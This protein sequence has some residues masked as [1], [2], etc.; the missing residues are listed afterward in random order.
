MKTLIHFREGLSGHYLKALLT[1][2]NT[3]IRFR[4][5]SAGHDFSNYRTWIPE[6]ERLIHEQFVCTHSV[7]DINVQDFDLVLKILVNKKIYHALYNVF[8]K[9]TLHESFTAEQ[10]ANWQQDLVF[11]YDLAYHNIKDYFDIFRR[12]W[13]NQHAQENIINFDWLLEESY[14]EHIFDQYFQRK[15]DTKIQQRITE[16][17]S[18]QLN[19]KLPVGGQTMEEI[20][21]P[22][23]D[24]YFAQHPWFAAYCIFK[25]E[26]NNNLPESGRLWSI[27][28]LTAPIDRAFLLAIANKY[29]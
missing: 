24:T 28:T 1:D 5:D 23:P 14:I 26:H 25:F 10:Y 17:R 6:E 15:L 4:I 13:Q 2:L 19:I 9:K 20:T 3:P 8:F 29:N 27:D 16:Y 22:I 18:Y 11:W 21:A 12:E 7:I